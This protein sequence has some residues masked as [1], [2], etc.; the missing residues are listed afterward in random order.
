MTKEYQ[1]WWSWLRILEE[2][3]C[4]VA[5]TGERGSLGKERGGRYFRQ[6]DEHIQR[7]EDWKAPW[8]WGM[9]KS[10]L[11]RRKS[12]RWGW[13]GRLRPA[14][15]G[16]SKGRGK[17][18]GSNITCALRWSLVAM[19]RLATRKEGSE[20]QRTGDWAAAR[21]DGKAVKWDTSHV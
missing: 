7:P 8:I 19:R 11:C 18:D 12:K 21:E 5:L 15:E 10:F 20:A 1:S 9:G 13:T 4:K 16:W 17:V 6:G 2:V 14:Q 3:T